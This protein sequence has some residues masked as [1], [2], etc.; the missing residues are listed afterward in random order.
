[1]WCMCNV[2]VCPFSTRWCLGK[3]CVVSILTMVVYGKRLCGSP[4]S[5]LWVLWKRCVSPILT[6]DVGCKNVGVCPHPFSHVVVCVLTLCCCPPF[7][8]CGVC[9]VVCVPHSHQCGVCVVDVVCCT[10]FSPVWCLCCKRAVGAGPPFSNHGVVCGN[11]VCVHSHHCGGSVKLCVCSPF[12][13]CG[14]SVVCNVCVCP[15][16]SQWCLCCNVVC[17]SPIL[18][19][20]VL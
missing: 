5:Q 7:S 17:V 1:M 15:M 8:T 20:W 3:L 12:S 18:T 9:N 11:V 2:C 13:P 10:P 4:I 6:C 16:S 19:M 14:L